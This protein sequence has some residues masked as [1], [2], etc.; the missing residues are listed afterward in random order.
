MHEAVHCSTR[1][2]AKEKMPGKDITAVNTSQPSAQ[3][4]KNL[5]FALLK[6]QLSNTRRRVK[7]TTSTQRHGKQPLK[8]FLWIMIH[9]WPTHSLDEA[10]GEEQ[11]CGVK[12]VYL[13]YICI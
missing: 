6:N 2:K 10:G 9:K 12:S 8:S 1:F 4:W 13:K 11:R 5:T 3:F 7:Y